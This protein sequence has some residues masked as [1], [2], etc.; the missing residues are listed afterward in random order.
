MSYFSIPKEATRPI[1]SWRV[2]E[3]SDMYKAFIE[4]GFHLADYKFMSDYMAPSWKTADL[5]A[6]TVAY[7]YEADGTVDIT[8]SVSI[9]TH[10]FAA[11]EIAMRCVCGR[12]EYGRLG[13]YYS[14]EFWDLKTGLVDVA[15][16]I[17]K[18]G[19]LSP[20]HLRQ[21]GYSEADI[22]RIRKPFN[23]LYAKRGQG[24]PFAWEKITKEYDM[25]VGAA[26]PRM[27]AIPAPKK[28]VK[29][30]V[31]LNNKY[32]KQKGVVVYDSTA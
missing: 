1:H 12:T 8:S 28:P 24:D 19:A 26:I 17:E 16:W 11:I 7:P 22:Q 3:N 10:S 9:T 4:A 21:D 31:Q 27:V 6:T 14:R 29:Y 32:L 30:H 25:A 2:D 5:D 18:I 15:A 20:G 23:E 13:Q